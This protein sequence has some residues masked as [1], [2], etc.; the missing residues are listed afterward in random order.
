MELESHHRRL[1]SASNLKGS[2]DAHISIFPLLTQ[3]IACSVM[4]ANPV[5]VFRWFA[6]LVFFVIHAYFR[7]EWQKECRELYIS[8]C[9]LQR[10]GVPCEGPS[11]C[12]VQGGGFRLPQ[13]VR[14]LRA[15]TVD[16]KRYSPR[17]VPCSVGVCTL[18]FLLP[19]PCVSTAARGSEAFQCRVRRVRNG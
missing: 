19:R 2:R 15:E 17:V 10:K 14:K 7:K 9:A 13:K 8:R 12:G 3:C 4:M 6:V 1:L 18:T 11:P 16:W 5:L